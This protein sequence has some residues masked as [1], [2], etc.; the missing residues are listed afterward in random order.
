MLTW[1]ECHKRVYIGKVP[2]KNGPIPFASGSQRIERAITPHIIWMLCCRNDTKLLDSQNLKV[3][4]SIKFRSHGVGWTNELTR[5]TP[6]ICLACFY[7]FQ[8]MTCYLPFAIVFLPLR[9]SSQSPFPMI[10]PLQIEFARTYFK[11]QVY[12]SFESSKV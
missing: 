2:A 6:N 10:P 4:V 11:D 12:H 3:C 7:H 9:L 5:L 1:C 8:R